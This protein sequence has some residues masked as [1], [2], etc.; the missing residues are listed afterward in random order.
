[1]VTRILYIFFFQPGKPKTI[2]YKHE[3]PVSAK[4]LV[5]SVPKVQA[6]KKIN[7]TGSR[8]NGLMNSEPDK[9]ART[10]KSIHLLV[11]KVKRW[12]SCQTIINSEPI[13]WKNEFKGSLLHNYFNK[14]WLLPL[15][16]A[17]WFA[18]S[19]FS[20]SIFSSEIQNLTKLYNYKIIELF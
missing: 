16:F 15:S 5:S 8:I 7:E 17:Y 12:L 18:G 14:I 20:K 2:L 3:N 19:P 9:K 1:V 11:E 13:N 6:N 10:Y 4:L